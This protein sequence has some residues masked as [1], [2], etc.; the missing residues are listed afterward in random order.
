VG[1]PAL[2]QPLTITE[3]ITHFSL[4]AMVIATMLF[5]FFII[6]SKITFKEGIILVIGYL[7]FIGW[8]FTKGG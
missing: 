7:V 8:L 4:P 5:L 1:I 6:D 2:M 3:N